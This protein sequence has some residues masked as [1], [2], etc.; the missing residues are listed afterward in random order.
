MSTK[1]V[2][3]GQQF[4]LINER[5]YSMRT[6]SAVEAAVMVGSGSE[7]PEIFDHDLASYFIG[8]NG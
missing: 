3:P 7:K 8:N 1:G 6:F 5:R 2:N 4:L